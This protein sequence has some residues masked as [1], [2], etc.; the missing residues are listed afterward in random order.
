MPS[1]ENDTLIVYLKNPSDWKIVREYGIYR[2]RNW[3][4]HPPRILAN[5]SVKNIAFYLPSAFGKNKYSIRHFAEVKKVSVAPRRECCP[6]ER[7]NKKSDWKYYKID[8]EEPQLL[9]EPIYHFRAAKKKLSRREMIL[10]PTTNEK[11]FKASEFNFLFNGSYLEEK[12]WGEL[13]KINVYPEREWP[14][15]IDRTTSYYLDFAVFCRDGHFCIEVDGQQHLEKE[16]VRSD[17]KRMNETNNQ[18][19]K[20]YRFYR[21][22]LEPGKIN[23]TLDKIRKEIRNRKGLDT[24]GGLFPPAPVG[25]VEQQQLA[26]FSESHLDFLALRRRVKERFEREM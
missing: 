13:L 12:L 16:H 7:P 4:K 18:K 9:R 23:D 3:I 10:F 19:W 14:V 26:L 20:T 21:E 17:N 8:V 5:R 1:F 6:N 2:I 15:K 22:D 25:K 24:E 11:L